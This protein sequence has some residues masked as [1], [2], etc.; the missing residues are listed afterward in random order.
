[1]M[2]LDRAKRRRTRNVAKGVSIIVNE[3]KLGIYVQPDAIA[4]APDYAKQL[5][6]EAGVDHFIMRSS[7]GLDIPDSLNKAVEIIRN[8]GAKVCFMAGT[9]WGEA[10]IKEVENLASKSHESQFPMDAPGSAID[11]GIIAKLEKLCGRYKPDAICLTHAR[12]R[13]PGY[14]D[15]MFNDGSRDQAFLARM[16][17]AGVPRSEVVDARA[18]L[19]RALD[20]SSKDR[21]LKAAEQGL[22]GFVSELTQSRVL[23]RFF[24]FRCDA[25]TDSYRK[26]RQAVKNSGDI[27]FGSNAYSPIAAKVCGHDYDALAGICEFFQPLLPYMEWH[28]FEP[29]AAWGR[30]LAQHAHL[31]EPSAIEIAKRLFYL[32]DAVLP[33]SCAEMDTCGEGSDQAVYSTVSK[34]LQLCAQYLS[35]PYRLMPV[36]RGIDW[37]KSVTDSLMEEIRQYRFPSVIFMGCAYLTASPPP[38][39]RWF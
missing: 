4:D 11:D 2:F 23:E 35:K 21:L 1:M 27:Y 16:E 3:W 37:S 15:G 14:I 36:L 18:A 5:I 33:D 20:A 17:A 32:G 10:N 6:G 29:L 26:F 12:F 24:S 22:I 25:V 13:H 28:R 38:S 9:F 19:E 8:T 30:Y 7:Y 39:D 34:E 31:D